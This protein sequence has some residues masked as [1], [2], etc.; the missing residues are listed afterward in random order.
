MLPLVI[1]ANANWRKIPISLIDGVRSVNA[2]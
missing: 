1:A 2:Y